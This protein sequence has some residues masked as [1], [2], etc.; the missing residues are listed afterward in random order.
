[1]VMV[2]DIQ[3]RGHAFLLCCFNAKTGRG[4]M[5]GLR[6]RLVMTACVLVSVLALWGSRH[7]ACES[8][9]PSRAELGKSPFVY[10]LR[11]HLEVD[12]RMKVLSK[13]RYYRSEDLHLKLTAAGCP[14]GWAFRSLRLVEDDGLV[15]FGIGEGPKRHQRYILLAAQPSEA[16]K[17]LIQRK[18]RLLEKERGC[19]IQPSRSTTDPQKCEPKPKRGHFNYY[20][21]QNPVETFGFVLNP[22]GQYLSVRNDAVLEVHSKEGGR[23]ANPLFFETLEYA[24][25][26]VSAFSGASWRS[27][28]GGLPDRWETDC[29]DILRGLVRFSQGV[30]GR[31]MTLLDPQGLERQRVLYTAHRVPGSRLFRVRGILTAAEY[32]PIRVSG[33]KG[34]IWIESFA[35]ETYLDTGQGRILRDEIEIAF[36][37]ER[38]KKIFSISGS[39]NV[40]RISLVDECILTCPDTEEAVLTAFRRCAPP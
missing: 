1:M 30:Y 6:D 21:W 10:D 39:S 19:G 36:G 9:Q 26:A 28:D 5:S 13:T 22:R 34:R 32:T 29:E 18:V 27:Q 2:C 25:L 16:D 15:N 8:L 33:L 31:K 7:G 40:V 23:R 17:A 24:L 14:E 4:D 35:R 11:F 38:K 20:L 12:G 37:V 3:Q